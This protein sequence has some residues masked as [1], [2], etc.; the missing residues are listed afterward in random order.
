MAALDSGLAHLASLL[1]EVDPLTPGAGA[2]GGTGFG[3]LAWG[4]TLEPGSVA[5]AELIGLPAAAAAASAV[6]TGEGS[7]DGQSAA[8][9]VP[10]H[11]AEAAGPTPVALVAG[12]ITPDADT[13]A[14]AASL[15]LTDLAGSPGGRD[16]GPRDLALGGRPP[17]RPRAR[18]TGLGGV[19]SGYRP[20]GSGYGVAA[21]SSVG[22]TTSSVNPCGSRKYVA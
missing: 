14:F 6:V 5:V 10:A 20:P 15:S 11:V 17:L 13:S 3:L 18:L 9:K 1:P 16:E 8:G 22:Q 12:R 7:F 4:A 21:G 2:A 19:R